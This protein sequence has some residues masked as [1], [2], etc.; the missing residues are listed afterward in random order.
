[1]H[2]VRVRNERMPLALVEQRELCVLVPGVVVLDEDSRR[3]RD[4]PAVD[5]VGEV[6]QL[7]ELSATERRAKELHRPGEIGPDEDRVGVNIGSSRRSQ[8]EQRAEIDDVRYGTHVSSAG[9]SWSSCVHPRGL[10]PWR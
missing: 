10:C 4:E 9:V 1:M 5:R 6:R 2:E 3:P 8:L 7:L